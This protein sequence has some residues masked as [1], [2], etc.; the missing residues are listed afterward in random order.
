MTHGSFTPAGV[1]DQEAID[2]FHG[3]YQDGLEALR[4]A[5]LD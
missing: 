3:I 2:L 5:F 4:Q 1:S